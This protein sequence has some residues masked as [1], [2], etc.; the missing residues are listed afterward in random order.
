MTTALDNSAEA[1]DGLDALD[2]AQPQKVR[3]ANT[4]VV[5]IDAADTGAVTSVTR[6]STVKAPNPSGSASP[7]LR[8]AAHGA[9]NEVVGTAGSR[10]F[11]MVRPVSQP[12][13]RHDVASG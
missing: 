1:V 4:V 2:N 13:A 3:I 6:L 11:V 12:V 8:L 7:S 9:G 5:P 10:V